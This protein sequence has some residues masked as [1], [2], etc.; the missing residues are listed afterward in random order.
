MDQEWDLPVRVTDRHALGPLSEIASERLQTRDYVTRMLYHGN[1]KRVL[2]GNE[3]ELGMVN[4]DDEISTSMMSR[5]KT[6]LV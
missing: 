4:S 3:I 1:E 2:V 5:G 6:N